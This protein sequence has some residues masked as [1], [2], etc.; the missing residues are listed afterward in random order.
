MAKKLTGFADAMSE[1]L[2][3]RPAQES[4]PPMNP[5][6][7]DETTPKKEE[8]KLPMETPSEDPSNTKTFEELPAVTED[9]MDEIVNR[10]LKKTNDEKNSKVKR[11]RPKTSSDDVVTTSI[12]C[13]KELLQKIDVIS[14]ILGIT[15]S[16]YIT[17]ALEKEVATK[18][19]IYQSYVKMFG[20][21]KIKN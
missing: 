16:A 14:N 11:G 19:D 3:G 1:A 9:E 18:N 15:R 7:V 8:N 4:Q 6:V 5:P 13:S 2:M 17:A 21:M 12:Y 10:T 20:S